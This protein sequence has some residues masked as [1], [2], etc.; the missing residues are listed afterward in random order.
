MRTYDSGHR[1]E[2]R[3]TKSRRR[4][5]KRREK[6]KGEEA[7]EERKKKLQVRKGTEMGDRVEGQ[8]RF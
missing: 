4:R 7:Q 8:W 1:D 5:T 2:P 3:G 6:R